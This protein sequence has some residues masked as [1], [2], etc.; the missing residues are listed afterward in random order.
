MLVIISFQVFFLILILA[1]FSGALNFSFL[2]RNNIAQTI[3][4]VV[5]IK[6]LTIRKKSL[7]TQENLL[8]KRSLLLGKLL[9]KSYDTAQIKK[10]MNFN[11]QFL[12]LLQT[13]CQNNH[14]RSLRKK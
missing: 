1:K 5:K 7:S 13:S 3:D 10:I 9:L 4:S 11:F 2:G 6:Q 8:S 12:L 14:T